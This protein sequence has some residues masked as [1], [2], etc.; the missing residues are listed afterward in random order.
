MP[1]FEIT[2]LE[3][4]SDEGLL[5]EI[6]RVAALMPDHCLTVDVFN[7]Q[8]RISASALIRRFGSWSEAKRKASLTDARPVYFDAEILDDLRRVSDS[9][10]DAPFTQK[11]YLS[12]GGRY[13]IVLVQRR[14]GGWREA[15]EA[16]FAR[17][18]ELS[19]AAQETSVAG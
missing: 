14:F 10:R 17:W 8:S 16:A 5:N 7:S 19:A 13:S 2:W 18:E 3:D 15:L 12:H 9:A 1:K 6:R 11:F 4:T